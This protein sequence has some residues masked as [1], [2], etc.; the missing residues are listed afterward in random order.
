MAVSSMCVVANVQMA[1]SSLH[2]VVDFAD[3]IRVQL[4]VTQDADP[5][6]Q[7]PTLV[8]EQDIVD[9]VLGQIIVPM[10][11]EDISSLDTACWR[12]L[13]A[14]TGIPDTRGLHCVKQL[15][16]RGAGPER[17]EVP[18]GASGSQVGQADTGRQIG[19]MK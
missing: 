19:P 16:P 2:I 14:E 17:V 5:V 11:C 13:A 8:T 15:G 6:P 12:P 1:V 4:H 9:A 10:H 7:V 3:A 18:A